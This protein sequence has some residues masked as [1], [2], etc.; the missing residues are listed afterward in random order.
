MAGCG[1][2]EKSDE[3]P[4]VKFGRSALRC[5]LPWCAR[6]RTKV[7][8]TR[9]PHHRD[10]D[11]HHDSDTAM[12]T[13]CARPVSKGPSVRVTASHRG[14]H[15]MVYAKYAIYCTRNFA[16]A[17]GR[18]GPGQ[19]A[20]PGCRAVAGHQAQADLPSGTSDCTL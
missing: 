7:T 17:D 13:E 15:I 1:S 6:R 9:M 14:S 2:D 12:F 18:P 16:K 10:S 19:P 8:V 3:G 11:G 4:G 20:S 5:D